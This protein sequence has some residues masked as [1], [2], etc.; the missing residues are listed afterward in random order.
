MVGVLIALYAAVSVLQRVQ[1]R[2]AVVP[3]S[4]ASGYAHGEESGVLVITLQQPYYSAI[5]T[6]T[7]YFNAPFSFCFHDI[8][9]TTP[10]L[11]SLYPTA[12]QA[13]LHYVI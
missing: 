10:H 5:H 1:Q 12:P 11:T 6:S 9:F 4:I 8:E 3:D 2:S 7:T 13:F